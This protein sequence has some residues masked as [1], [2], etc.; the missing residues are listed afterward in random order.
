LINGTSHTINRSHGVPASST[1]NQ[2]VFPTELREMAP[3]RLHGRNAGQPRRP[4]T[5]NTGGIGHHVLWVHQIGTQEHRRGNKKRKGA[6]GRSNTS[7]GKK[8]QSEASLNNKAK[9]V[10]SSLTPGGLVAHKRKISPQ[11]LVATPTNSLTAE[12]FSHTSIK[13]L[14]EG[15]KEIEHH[16]R[17]EGKKKRRKQRNRRSADCDASGATCVTWGMGK[18]GGGGHYTQ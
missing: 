5:K 6:E 12:R 17:L 10:S 1:Q 7:S 14:R 3:L 9:P 8:K 18:I 13:S 2:G 16:G 11:S 4:L 15:R